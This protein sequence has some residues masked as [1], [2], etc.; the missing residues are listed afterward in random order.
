[1]DPVKID[2]LQIQFINPEKILQ[3]KGKTLADLV[4]DFEFISLDLQGDDSLKLGKQGKLRFGGSA[5]ASYA[6]QVFN[7]PKDKDED[8]VW[9]Q[10]QQ[11]T[12]AATKHVFTGSVG[13][14]GAFSALNLSA[15]VEA[16]STIK[17]ADYKMHKLKDPVDKALLS[18]ITQIRLACRF[19]D[20]QSMQNG[21][22]LLYQVRGSFGF[23]VTL[24]WG[25]ILSFNSNVLST[26][27]STSETISLK[28]SLSAGI[29]FGMALSDELQMIA[30]KGQDGKVRISFNKTGKSESSLALELKAIVGFKNLDEAIYDFIAQLTGFD[31]TKL[32]GLSDALDQ[33]LKLDQLSPIQRKIALELLKRLGVDYE[34]LKDALQSE[35]DKLTAPIEEIARQKATLGFQYE[36]SRMTSDEVLLELILDPQK[37]AEKDYNELLVGNFDAA[38][39]SGFFSVLEFLNIKTTERRRAYGISLS[40]GPFKLQSKTELPFKT[41]ETIDKTQL[42]WTRKYAFES[43]MT[44]SERFLSDSSQPKVV[45]SAQ[46]GKFREK[47]HANDFRFAIDCNWTFK[48]AILSAG[49]FQKYMDLACL[50]GAAGPSWWED[51]AVSALGNQ[52]QGK[53]A[54]F[55]IHLLIKDSGVRMMLGAADFQEVWFRSLAAA[56]DFSEGFKFRQRRT[57][58]VRACFYA[59]AIRRAA[60]TGERSYPGIG[61][62]CDSVKYDPPMLWFDNSL[63]HEDT[64]LTGSLDFYFMELVSDLDR[65]RN[66][67]FVEGWERWAQSVDPNLNPDKSIALLSGGLERMTIRSETPFLLRGLGRLFVNLLQSHPDQYSS[68]AVFTGAQGEEWVIIGKK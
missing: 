10:L 5:S 6:V 39:T 30:Q 36:Y 44:G 23:S 21:E 2:N 53:K 11:K 12:E 33:G 28:L 20:I 13:A 7:N 56:T 38:L 14:E 66:R 68:T 67:R 9:N 61:Q 1:M 19:S 58:S 65:A 17:F 51:P 8:K 43:S 57:P 37:E 32:K 15:S 42:P 52:L 4:D 46:M 48:E 25:E 35:V 18:D 59:N 60:T 50:W 54:Q 64:I 62:Q 47:P 55:S 22:A 49:E 3:L 29:K 41:V 63:S 24:T 31:L 40:L 16:K 27:L 45:F 34:G 26:F